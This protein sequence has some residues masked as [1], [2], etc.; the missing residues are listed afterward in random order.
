MPLIQRPLRDTDDIETRLAPRAT[1]ASEVALLQ[2]AGLIKSGSTIESK[3]IEEMQ[4][5]GLA[6]RN[7]LAQ[8]AILM[9]GAENDATKLAAAKLAMSLYMH[10]ALVSSK[11]RMNQAQPIIN[12]E[13]KVPE[14]STAT[15]NLDKILNPSGTIDIP[16]Q[17]KESW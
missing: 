15:V 5:V 8:I 6:T 14:G 16:V 7:V 17:N 11:E 1:Y 13:I 4:D 2:Q 12:F 3:I 9:Q 10:P